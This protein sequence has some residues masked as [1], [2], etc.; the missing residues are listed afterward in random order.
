MQE[1]PKR[2]HGFDMEQRFYETME[3][4]DET[5]AKVAN[6]ETDVRRLRSENGF[7]RNEM[8]QFR[9]ENALLSVVAKEFCK[10]VIVNSIVQFGQEAQFSHELVSRALKSVGMSGQIQFHKLRRMR[11]EGQHDKATIIKQL[12]EIEKNHVDGNIVAVA[13]ELKDRILQT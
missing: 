7:V 12:Q 2:Q 11:N 13:R 3:R 5:N 6:L 4:L 10:Q 9:K 1:R 8:E